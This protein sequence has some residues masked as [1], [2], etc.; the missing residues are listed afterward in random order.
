[1]NEML[2]CSKC[3]R[4]IDVTKEGYT[5]EHAPPTPEHIVCVDCHRKPDDPYRFENG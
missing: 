5:I 4:E 3:G 1:M 2:L